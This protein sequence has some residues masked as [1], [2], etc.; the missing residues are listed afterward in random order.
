[1]CRYRRLI[2]LVGRFFLS[3]NRHTARWICSID[4][5][6]GY[7]LQ[8]FFTVCT[9]ERYRLTRFCDTPAPFSEFISRIKTRQQGRSIRIRE[10]TRNIVSLR[11]WITLGSFVSAC[12]PNSDSFEFL[13][14]SLLYSTDY[15]MDMHAS[16]TLCTGV[17]HRLRPEWDAWGNPQKWNLIPTID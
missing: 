12:L 13:L 1:M 3:K 17:R 16:K 4:T 11:F 7:L 2:Y 14:I 6:V 5:Q 9:V 8:L 10:P 15:V